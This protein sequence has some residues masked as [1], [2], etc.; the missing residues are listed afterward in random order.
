MDPG[1][2]VE[3][4][5]EAGAESVRVEVPD[6]GPGVAGDPP[7]EPSPERVG[8]RGLWLVDRLA[9]PWGVTPCSPSCVWLEIDRLEPLRLAR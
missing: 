2:C 1:Q 4:R 6:P 7:T 5:V 8:G 9:S 3:L